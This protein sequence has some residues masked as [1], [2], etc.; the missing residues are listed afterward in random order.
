MKLKKIYPWKYFEFS[1]TKIHLAYSLLFLDFLYR[2]VFAGAEE[3]NSDVKYWNT[4]KLTN[5]EQSM[6]LFLYATPNFILKRERWRKFG[7]WL[8]TL[9]L[10]FF[11]FF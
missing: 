7:L 8:K 5:M 9:K 1:L 11:L 10:I 3:F 4:D 2:V 6:C